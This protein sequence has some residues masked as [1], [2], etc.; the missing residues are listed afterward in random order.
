[1]RPHDI[2]VVNGKDVK[3]YWTADPA[4]RALAGCKNRAVR[5]L[6]ARDCAKARQLGIGH[7]VRKHVDGH[8]FLDTYETLDAVDGQPERRQANAIASQIKH[9][10]NETTDLY[11]KEWAALCKD[12][13][14]PENYVADTIYTSKYGP[15]VV[16]NT[17]VHESPTT[18]KPKRGPGR[19]RK[20]EAL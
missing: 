16:L 3:E 11:R 17:P 19:P 7:M 2:K 8:E 5:T 12:P 4:N 10:A 6:Q 15:A 18:E 20:S 13:K 14:S 1:M 9:S